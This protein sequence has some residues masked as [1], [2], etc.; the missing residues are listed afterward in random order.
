ML[1]FFFCCAT[2]SNTHLV[3]SLCSLGDVHVP[4]HT[5]TLED[6][7]A[8]VHRRLQG[9]TLVFCRPDNRG[10]CLH[11]LDTTGVPFGPVGTFNNTL[12]RLHMCSHQ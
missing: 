8:G 1:Q 5:V 9:P 6:T 10:W 12:H 7:H 2:S 11:H 3:L 4:R